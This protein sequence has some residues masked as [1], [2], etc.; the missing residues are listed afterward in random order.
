M[1]QPTRVKSARHLWVD[2][3]ST[4]FG[5]GYSGN[6][7]SAFTL[8]FCLHWHGFNFKMEMVTYGV[9]F[10]LDNPYKWQDIVLLHSAVE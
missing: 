4:S 3:S 7:S 8:N 10:D 6:V 9:L 2:K 1:H 5:W